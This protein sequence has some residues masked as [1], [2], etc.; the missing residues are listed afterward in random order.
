MVKEYKLNNGNVVSGEIIYYN[1]EKNIGIG[2]VLDS[3]DYLLFKN[4]NYYTISKNEDL[5]VGLLPFL[6][7]SICTI[8]EKV[9]NYDLFKI[10]P[11]EKIILTAFYRDEKTLT[12]LFSLYWKELA[13]NWIEEIK[14]NSSSI[15]K[16]L[17]IEYNYIPKGG[18][19]DWR[20]RIKYVYEL[21]TRG[22]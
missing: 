12:C 6:E 15:L 13:L 16:M 8:K 4:F 10:L 20:K 11:V 17:E 21:I 14:L 18:L 3:N 22:K 1:R 2:I 19:K 9:E 5:M 7:I